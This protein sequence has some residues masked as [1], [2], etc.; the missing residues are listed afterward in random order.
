[1]LF[2][3]LPLFA[4]F[5]LGFVLIR[6]MTLRDMSLRPHQ[7]FGLVVG[8]YATQSLLLSLRWGY[9]MAGAA[10]L[11]ALLAPCLPVFAY[12]AYLSL[13]DP[14]TWKRLWPMGIIGL[15]WLAYFLEP[16]LA[17]PLILLTY[18]G[19]GILLLRLAWGGSDRLPL[20]RISG[21]DAVLNAMRLTGAA[22]VASGMTDIYLIY[23]FVFHAGQNIGVIVTFVQTAFVLMI[24]L[25]A[26][27]GQSV[28]EE[29]PIENPQAS[30][31]DSEV[32]AR[33]TVLFETEMLY[34]D[35]D[36]SLRRLSRRLGLPD[37]SVSQ[38]VNRLR[39]MNLS[40]FVNDFRVRDACHLLVD[41]D[42][43]VLEISLIVGFATKS[44]FN[45]EFARVTGQTPS[46]WR[47]EKA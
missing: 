5:V 28:V 45:R 21:A 2:V 17:D 7:L 38:A 24:G 3:P 32:I 41:T 31:E 8:L 23:D 4:T 27:R 6:L 16:R 9:E 1:M 44:N 25:S 39:D 20:T 33:L 36:L 10:P 34:R 26:A 19:F 42:K 30:Q 35:E 43:S 46:S 14:L 18:I 11:I 22:L 37:R 13:S 12:L 40:Q 15:N 29:P 47:T